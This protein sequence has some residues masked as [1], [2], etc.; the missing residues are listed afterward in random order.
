MNVDETTPKAT[1]TRCLRVL[2]SRGEIESLRM[3]STAHVDVDALQ[4]ICIVQS[5][6]YPMR[7]EYDNSSGLVATIDIHQL[8]RREKDG[9]TSC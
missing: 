5:L 6:M 9:N 3:H 7:P 2:E 8:S 1:S 4:R